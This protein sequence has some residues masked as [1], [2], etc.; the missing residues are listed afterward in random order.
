[1]AARYEYRVFELEMLREILAARQ[2][3]SLAP[4]AFPGA[5][6]ASDGPTD[7]VLDALARGFRWV[8]T[9]VG[10]AVFERLVES[11]AGEAPIPPE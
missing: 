8:R 5:F 6:L 9:D 11:D 10:V 4:E 2:E 7:A 3:I 1:M